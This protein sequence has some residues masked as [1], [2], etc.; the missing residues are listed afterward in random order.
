MQ[1][2]NELTPAMPAAV[3]KHDLLNLAALR[4]RQIGRD[5]EAE[6]E[7]PEVPAQGT[8]ASRNFSA[9]AWSALH[10]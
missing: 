6:P 7:F 2:Q 5:V 8:P 4:R 1:D 3:L 10:D 9:P